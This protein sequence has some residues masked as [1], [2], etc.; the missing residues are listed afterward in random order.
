MEAAALGDI[1]VACFILREEQHGRDPARTLADGVIAAKQRAA[2]PAPAPP[3]SPSPPR[4]PRDPDDRM[5][6]RVELRL[7]G[8]L[9][10][11]HA[12][13]E[14]A[15]AEEARA[16]EPAAAAE[17]ADPDAHPLVAPLLD[18]GAY[19]PEQAAVPDPAGAPVEP[20]HDKEEEAASRRRSVRPGPGLF[21]SDHQ[22]RAVEFLTLLRTVVADPPPDEPPTP[23]AQAP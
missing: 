20:G 18:G 9:Q 14:A 13:V 17:A 7:R 6:E 16:E 2:R 23:R 15:V 19:Q 5:I 4:A 21:L 10:Q 12:A 11:E 1:R 8:E 22:R 3:V